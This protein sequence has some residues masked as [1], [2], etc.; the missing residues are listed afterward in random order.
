MRRAKNQGGSRPPTT[1]W[2]PAALLGLGINTI[3]ASVMALGAGAAIGA[4]VTRTLGGG[5]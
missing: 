1:P 2:I 4:A 3:A 5:R